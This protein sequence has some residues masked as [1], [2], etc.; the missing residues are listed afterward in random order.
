MACLKSNENDFR[1]YLL[2]QNVSQKLS[3]ILII[4]ITFDLSYEKFRRSHCLK[5]DTNRGLEFQTRGR[6]DSVNQAICDLKS[7]GTL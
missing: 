4:Y 7:L 5:I 2:D 6:V 1:G 3:N